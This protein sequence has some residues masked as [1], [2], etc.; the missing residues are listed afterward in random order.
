MFKFVNSD[1]L[2]AEVSANSITSFK[3]G[4]QVVCDLRDVKTV[5][6]SQLKMHFG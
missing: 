3:A 2:D 4:L 5:S 1:A 6:T